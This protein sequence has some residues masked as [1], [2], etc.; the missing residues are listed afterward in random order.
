MEFKKTVRLSKSDSHECLSGS[1]RV[2]SDGRAPVLQ[3]AH[4]ETDPSERLPAPSQELHGAR[5]GVP[6]LERPAREW[7][8]S[9]SLFLCGL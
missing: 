5:P 4:P 9:L 3:S 2:S 8:L 7:S 6:N 1:L